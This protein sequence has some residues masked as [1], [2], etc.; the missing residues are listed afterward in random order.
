MRDFPQHFLM[1]TFVRYIN[2][3]CRHTCTCIPWQLCYFLFCAHR[4]GGTCELYL[5]ITCVKGGGA[6]IRD[7]HLVFDR[8]VAACVSQVSERAVVTVERGTKVCYCH[9]TMLV[10]EDVVLDA[11]LRLEPRPLEPHPQNKDRLWVVLE[12]RGVELLCRG[13]LEGE[14]TVAVK[15]EFLHNHSKYDHLH[16][17]IDSLTPTLISRLLLPEERDFPPKCVQPLPPALGPYIQPCSQDQR[18][19]LQ[20]I[21]SLPPNSPPLLVRGAFG[22]GKTFL[23]ATAVHCLLQKEG[24]GGGA[25]RVLVCTPD[26]TTSQRFLE[27]LYTMGHLSDDVCVI[28]LVSRS[29]EVNSRRGV[30]TALQ[31]RRDLGRILKCPSLLL[32]TSYLCSAHLVPM[33]HREVFSLMLLDDGSRVMEPEGVVP[34]TMVGPS[35]RV[36]MVGDPAQVR[37]VWL[38]RM[39]EPAQVRWV[40]LVRVGEPA[41]VRWVWLVRVGEPAQVRGCGL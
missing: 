13:L 41:L 38:V 39:G 11:I 17:S 35:T 34:L 15:V 6:Q 37:W 5:V 40:W 29:A 32:V 9:G 8:G 21:L 22:T 18:N 24:G 4:C 36:V 25:V 2:W 28:Q 3:S 19:A 23:L 10:L 27:L 16:R 7:A 20:T 26:H 33:L 30:V 12:Q 1:H 31:L 14:L